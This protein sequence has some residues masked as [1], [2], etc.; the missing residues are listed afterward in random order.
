[1]MLK[2]YHQLKAK[3]N[4]EALRL[5][6]VL[7]KSRNENDRLRRENKLLRTRLKIEDDAK[8]IKF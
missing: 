2:T 8:I 5:R 6:D 3:A 4:R 7:K 1:M